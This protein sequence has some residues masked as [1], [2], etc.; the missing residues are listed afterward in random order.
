MRPHREAGK[1]ASASVVLSEYRRERC[2]AHLMRHYLRAAQE[3][4]SEGRA[5]TIAHLLG[6]DVEAVATVSGGG[7]PD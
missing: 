7:E 4:V 5:A 2:Y 1:Q 3:A 6:E